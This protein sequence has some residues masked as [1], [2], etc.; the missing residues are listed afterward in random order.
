LEFDKTSNFF[1]HSFTFVNSFWPGASFRFRKEWPPP[2][3][4]SWMFRA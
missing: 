3:K 2:R 1:S 4:A